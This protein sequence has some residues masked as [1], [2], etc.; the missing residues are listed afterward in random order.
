MNRGPT[1]DDQTTKGKMNNPNELDQLK[2]L[3][4]ERESYWKDEC[5][6]LMT[7]ANRSKNEVD[8]LQSTIK[9]LETVVNAARKLPSQE[10]RNIGNFKA[11][12]CDVCGFYEALA[13]LDEKEKP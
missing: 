7:D 6:K 11:P 1:E 5:A 12:H 3:L 13:A 9:A 4:Q 8:Q 10:C 2:A